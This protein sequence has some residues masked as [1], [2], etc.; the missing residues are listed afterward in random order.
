MNSTDFDS[1]VQRLNVA[2]TEKLEPNADILRR[3]VQLNEMIQLSNGDFLKSLKN[4][5]DYN[6]D[7]INTLLD[8]LSVSSLV[9]DTM[10]VACFITN[11]GLAKLA[12]AT[13]GSLLISEVAIGDANGALY[14]ITG[15]ETALVNEVWR[16]TASD[17]QNVAGFVDRVAF[18]GQ[19][20]RASGPYTVR[21]IGLFDSDGDLFAVGITAAFDKQDPAV[22]GNILN[23]WAYVQLGSEAQKLKFSSGNQVFNSLKIRDLTTGVIREVVVNNGVL[24]I[25]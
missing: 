17:P 25:L 13:E 16:G 18:S 2:V 20:E 12:A 19:V 24:Q 7:R 10:S 8:S 21:E 22:V 11:A 14:A 1:L 5:E 6:Q 3:Y 15:D 9:G 4:F 23:L